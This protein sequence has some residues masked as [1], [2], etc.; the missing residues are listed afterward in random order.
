MRTSVD[1]VGRPTTNTTRRVK[2][3]D[4]QV[5]DLFKV[6][7]KTYMHTGCRSCPPTERSVRFT[8]GSKS[9][10][11]EIYKAQGRLPNGKDII[12][13]QSMVVDGAPERGGDG[14]A[15]TTNGDR[16]VLYVGRAHLE[17][18]FAS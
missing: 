5:G 15:F 13:W 6:N 16:E 4:L 8:V 18:E 9:M 7:G 11:H 2:R 12:G 17:L 10:T 3:R 14:T 1:L